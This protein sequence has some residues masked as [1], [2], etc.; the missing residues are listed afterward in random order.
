MNPRNSSRR[1][2]LDDN[3]RFTRGDLYGAEQ[4][5]LD[6]S[7]WDVVALPHDWSIAGLQTGRVVI[8]TMHA[9]E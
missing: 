8:R 7:A 4:G 1:T 6:D 9:S 3:W 2:S 5:Q